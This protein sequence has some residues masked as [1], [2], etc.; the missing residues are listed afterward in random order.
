MLWQ[1]FDYLY[2]HWDYTKHGSPLVINLK[3]LLERILTDDAIPKLPILIRNSNPW[4]LLEIIYR[5]SVATGDVPRIRLEVPGLLSVNSLY[6]LRVF[7]V[8]EINE[9]SVR[10]LERSSS[11]SYVYSSTGRASSTS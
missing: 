9:K 3:F 11:L 5:S 7:S 6:T 8:S 2:D 1:I 10:F 4:N